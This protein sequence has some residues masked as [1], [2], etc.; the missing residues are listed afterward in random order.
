MGVWVGMW[1]GMWVGVGVGVGVLGGGRDEMWIQSRDE[2]SDGGN[3]EK[4]VATGL[5]AR[6][7]D[8]VRRKVL[9][10]HDNQEKGKH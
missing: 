5:L 6:L 3:L 7:G 8:L 4:P 1:V 9:C 10:N 2:L